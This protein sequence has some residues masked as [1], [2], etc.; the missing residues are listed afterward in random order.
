M[1]ACAYMNMLNDTLT[2]GERERETRNSA[3]TTANSEN[4]C[5]VITKMYTI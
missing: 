1:G 5:I 2:R 4:S 3:M